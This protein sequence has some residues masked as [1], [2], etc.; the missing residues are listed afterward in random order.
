LATVISP[1]NVVAVEWEYEDLG[2]MRAAWDAWL[3][4]PGTA[5]Y[6]EQFLGLYRPGEHGDIWQLAAYR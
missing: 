3:A 4:K 1:Y 2:Q 5:E 6:M